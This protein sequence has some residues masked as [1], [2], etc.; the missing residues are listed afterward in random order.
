MEQQYVPH[1]GKQTEFLRCTADWVFFGGARGGSKSFSL[2]WKAGL[3]PRT[4]HYEREGYKISKTDARKYKEI[5]KKVVDVIDK[6]SIDYPEYIGILIRKTHPQ[7]E[8]NLKPECEKLY[9]MFGGVWRERTRCY[10]FPSGARIYLVHLKDEA[11]LDNYIGGNYH[12]IGV[13]EANQFPE[14]WIKKL[15]TSA[16]TTNPELQPQICLTSNPGN[17][18]HLWLK[19][20]FVETC[21]PRPLGPRLYNEKFDCYYQPTK[22]GKPYIR[23]NISYQF[24]P[25]TVFDNPAILENDPKYVNELKSLPPTLKAMWLEGSWDV[26]QGMYFDMWNEAHH[27]I[28]KEDFV[29]NKHFNKHTHNLYRFYDY[30]TKDPFICLF[31]AVDKNENMIIFDEIV[32]TGF[33]ASKQAKHVVEYTRG[34]Y[35]LSNEDFQDEICDPAFFTKHSEKDGEPYSPASFYEDEGVY[36]TKANNDRKAGAKVVYNAFTVPDEDELACRVRFTDN[37]VESIETFPTLPSKQNDPEDVDTKAFDHIYDALR[38]GCMEVLEAKRPTLTRKMGWRETLAL[39]IK[40]RNYDS[41]DG[42][43]MGR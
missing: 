19:K 4:W 20:M 43:W 31:A 5:G 36:L 11:A 24:I 37:C 18:G 2:A 14:E 8:R 27:V 28:R 9:P 35:G 6:I 23:D 17:L 10:V 12:F 40:N 21:P 42:T 13:D 34:N 16:R 30:G 1:K 39:E 26:F 32:E 25:A 29:Y 22:S 38:Y 7:L 3:T 15:G 33:A 41:G